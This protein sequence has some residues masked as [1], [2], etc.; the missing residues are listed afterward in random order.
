VRY[1]REDS[2][3]R[4]S[5]QSAFTL[6]ELLVVISIIAVLLIAIVPAVN[7]LFKSS[8]RKGALSGLLG[9]IEQARS[10]AVKDGQATYVVFPDQLVN[11]NDPSLTQRYSYRSYAIFE[12]DAANPGTQKQVT[13]WQSL[14]TGISIRSGSLNYLAK[15]IA[16]PFTPLGT[17][18][19]GQFPFLKFTANG[20]VDP[21]TTRDPS[22]T[23]G[24]IQ[25]GIFE[26][27]VDSTGIDKKTSAV[28]FTDSIEVSRLTGHAQ[29]M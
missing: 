11:N 10:L 28:D 1:R 20:E 7:P 17:G 8:G 9:A 23:T 25:F 26:G 15:T 5:P 22:K 3:Q 29:R 19:K 13:P 16:F 27:F 14:A 6:L 2:L 24:T 4:S 18:V 12:D 21:A